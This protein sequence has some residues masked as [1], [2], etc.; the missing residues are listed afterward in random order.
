MPTNAEN[1]HFPVV[2]ESRRGPLPVLVHDDWA[3]AFPWLVQGTTTSGALDAARSEDP[4]QAR[5]HPF[6][7][8]LFSNGSPE[9]VVR[10]HWRDLADG[11]DVTR[12]VHASQPHG[13]DVRVWHGRERAE[14]TGDG[15]M[16]DA[17]APVP[18]LVEACDGHVT[19]RPGV[20]LAVTVAD[21]VP[22]FLVDP[23]A[24]AVAMVHAGWR[25][26]AAGILE[27]ALQTMAYHFD[28]RPADT[29][30]HLG[31]SI[32]GRCYEVGPEV[33]EALEQPVP[34]SPT[35]IDLK[36]ILGAR[37]RRQGVAAEK[38]SVSGHCTLCGAAGLFSHRGGDA[39]RQV[40][41]IGIRS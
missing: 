4:W 30:V 25:G 24:R 8:G 6:D 28:T 23:T 38:I 40:G 41:F 39:Q 35:P 1:L 32:C 36:T 21:C 33:H 17:R 26:A 15:P 5:E 19:R 13:S 27:S 14:D 11:L 9:A 3:S 2:H 10:A 34:P 29:C 37:A 20:V 22:V 16:V 31:P 12:M 18:V 7:L